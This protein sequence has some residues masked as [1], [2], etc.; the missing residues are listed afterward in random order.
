MECAIDSLLI[1]L[2][3]SQIGKARSEKARMARPSCHRDY[4]KACLGASSHGLSSRTERPPHRVTTQDLCSFPSAEPRRRSRVVSPA[5]S[6]PAG[7]LG[8]AA[9]NT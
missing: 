1:D 2:V 3:S 4:L 6:L 5:A 9:A 7:L 8:G